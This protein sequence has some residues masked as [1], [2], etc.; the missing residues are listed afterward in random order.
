MLILT[1]QAGNT[2]TFTTILDNTTPSLVVKDADGN[3]TNERYFSTNASIYWQQYKAIEINNILDSENKLIVDTNITATIDTNIFK[4]NGAQKYLV[5]ENTTIDIL[6]SAGNN[7]SSAQDAT[8]T[9]NDKT[10]SASLVINL[11]DIAAEPKIILRYLKQ[12]GTVDAI[13]ELSLED[14]AIYSFNLYDALNNTSFKA[15]TFS[16]NIIGI[17]IT[18]CKNNDAKENTIPFPSS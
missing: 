18:F 16:I 9:V 3:V 14:M 2:A 1:D 13:L 17:T 8:L 7:E 10:T 12:N 5:V 6:G 15:L 11:D 4:T